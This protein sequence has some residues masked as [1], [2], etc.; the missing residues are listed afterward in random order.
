MSAPSMTKS[1]DISCCGQYRYS[2][3]RVWDPSLPLL[4]ITMLNPSK[5]DASIN[6]PTVVRCI[7]FA[8]AWGYGG[9]RIVNLYAYRATNP[10]DLA[11]AID[12][13]GPANDEYLI[14]AARES[15]DL[16]APLVAAWGVNAEPAR[17]WR[18]VHLPGFDRLTSLGVTKDGHPRHPLYV[19]A[20]T[21]LT[22]WSW[23]S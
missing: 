14:N 17:I 12:P 11:K 20:D 5:A 19:R 13:V 4:T 15:A 10:K 16:G 21:Q 23:R 2:L 22:P 18:V 8:R 9:I 7:G 6:D 1:A 3:T